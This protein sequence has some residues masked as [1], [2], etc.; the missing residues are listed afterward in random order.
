MHTIAVLPGDGIGE[1]V[2]RESLRVL[3]TVSAITGF[4]YRTETY[5]YGAE[6]YLKTG[7]TFPDSALREMRDHSAI[8]L[9]AIGDP[10]V[11][12]GYLE[13]AIIGYKQKDTESAEDNLSKAESV[14]ENNELGRLIVYF[15]HTK[16]K[17]EEEK[18][19]FETAV[20]ILKQFLSLL[21]R[22]P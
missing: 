2:V 19:N 9:G 21:C 4:S 3:E 15:L 17:V 10:R 11:E 18:K 16:A 20:D 13:R 1:E 12:T 22:Y 14:L 6:H 7:E 8:L 5:P